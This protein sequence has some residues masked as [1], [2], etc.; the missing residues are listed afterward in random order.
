M[1]NT[2]TTG[3]LPE[4]KFSTGVISATVWNNSGTSKK[5]GA[6]FEFRT[7]KL[8]RRYTD[9]DGS[10]KSTNSLRLNDLPKAALVLNKAYE[11]L[12]IKEQ[13]ASPS[14]EI[15]INEEIIM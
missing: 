15:P 7:I 8:E 11:Y 4:K 1:E 10:W 12:V 5:D 3:N 9:K 2:N 6:Q 14:G 13:D